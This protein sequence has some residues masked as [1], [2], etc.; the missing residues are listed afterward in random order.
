MLR[1]LITLGVF[2]GL[3]GCVVAPPY[4]YTPAPAYYAAPIVS[5]G[6]GGG[7]RIR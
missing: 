3:S 2:A 7:W 4:A 6:V 5:V 1:L